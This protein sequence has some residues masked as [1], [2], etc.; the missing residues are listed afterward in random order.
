MVPRRPEQITWP[1]P[2][3]GVVMGGGG[4]GLPSPGW[5]AGPCSVQVQ[6]KGQ[7]LGF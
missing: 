4:W 3:L 5:E 2:E 6:E 7:G 1:N